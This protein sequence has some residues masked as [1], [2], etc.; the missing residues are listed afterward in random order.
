MSAQSKKKGKSARNARSTP[1]TTATNGVVDAYGN[2]WRG[3][4]PISEEVLSDVEKQLQL[5]IPRELR[6]HLLNCNGGEPEKSYFTDGRIE[7]GLGSLFPI[8]PPKSYKGRSFEAT[9]ERVVKSALPSKLLPFGTDNGNSGI[10]CLDMVSGEVVYWV[11]DEPEDPIKKVS[12]TLKAFLTNL[13]VP[14]Y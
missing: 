10:Y 12:K 6:T 13:K 2:R 11:H 14:P 1:S 3:C 7:V 5:S 4:L 8:R 9:Y